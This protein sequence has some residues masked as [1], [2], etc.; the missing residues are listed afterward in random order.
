[1]K[2]IKLLLGTL[3]LTLAAL[4]PFAVTAPG[5]HAAGLGECFYWPDGGN[6]ATLNAW[7][8]GPFV[9][10]WH[11]CAFPNDSFFIA[12][13]QNSNDV[14]IEFTG[15]SGWAGHCVGDAYNDPNNASTSLDTCSPAGWGT[16]FVPLE[17]GYCASNQIAFK[18]VHWSAVTGHNAYLGPANP[19]GDGSS[20]YLN[21]TGYFCFTVAASGMTL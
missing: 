8:G 10:S 18:N 5:A 1:M 15:N 9:K 7:N 17:S 19:Y 6:H 20:F 14:Q 2:Q 13:V 21:K 4:I 12:S 11:S 3:V 16:L